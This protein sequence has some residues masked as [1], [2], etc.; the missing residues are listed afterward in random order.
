M[1]PVG[2]LDPP[3]GSLL[4]GLQQRGSNTVYPT[5]PLPAG[6]LEGFHFRKTN[7]LVFHTILVYDYTGRVQCKRYVKYI[8]YTLRGFRISTITQG[9]QFCK[10]IPVSE[11]SYRF[12]EF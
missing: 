3:P 9:R 11:N 4:E 12:L 10:G 8:I 5:L 2:N 1:R 7:K 6:T